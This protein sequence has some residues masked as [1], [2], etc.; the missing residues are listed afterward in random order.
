MFWESNGLFMGFVLFFSA[1][2]FIVLV[3][4][5]D[6]GP[7]TLL[8]IEL[9]MEQTPESRGRDIP[10]PKSRQDTIRPMDAVPLAAPRP[11]PSV[12][13]E[14]QRHIDRVAVPSGLSRAE[15]PE[16]PG[17]IEGVSADAADAAAAFMTRAEYLE[18][19][20][21]RVEALKSYPRTA[22]ERGHHGAVKVRFQ[23]R[24]D[25]TVENLK[26]HTGSGV[27][28]LDR[29]A[30]QAVRKAT[31]FPRPPK[32]MFEYPLTLHLTIVFNLL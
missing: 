8:S 27:D 1:L 4:A 10:R 15:L 32:G 21:M 23:M 30:L 6:P 16:V 22:R 12:K 25:G 24:Q 11:L 9:E 26:V 5:Q 29:S 2:L 31:P 28:E 20:R 18:L 19:L 17:R 3:F 14:N 7:D 13:Q